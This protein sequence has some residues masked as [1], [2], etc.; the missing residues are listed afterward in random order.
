MPLRGLG[1]MKRLKKFLEENHRVKIL[2]PASKYFK[3]LKDDHL[4]NLFFEAIKL[5]LENPLIGEEKHG[6][7]RGI[8]SYDI[9]YKKV[10]YELSYSVFFEN[11]ELVVVIMAGPRENFYDDLKRY[12]RS[13]QRQIGGR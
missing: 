6:D 9:Y 11:E 7:L 12:L 4:K 8:R 3:K 5:I 13:Q 1:N 2:P 10:N